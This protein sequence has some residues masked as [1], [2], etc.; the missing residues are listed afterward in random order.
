MP[1]VSVVIPAFN[2]DAFIGET[3][4]SVLAQTRRDLEIFVV[5]D[6]S[7]DTTREIVAAFGP[8][9]RLLQ[10][11]RGGPARARNAGARASAGTWLAFLD[12][13]DLWTPDKLER[14][15]DRAVETG[16]AMVVTD[17]INIG[18]RGSL[19]QRQSDIQPLADGDIFEALLAGNFITTSTVLLRRDA[20]EAAGGFGEDPVLPPAE[21][22]DFW[23]RVAHDHRVAACPEPLVYYRHHRAGISRNVQRMNASRVEVITR[24][25]GLPRGQALSAGRRRRIWAQTWSTN[26]WDAAR[27]GAHGAAIRAYGNAIRAW[28]SASGPYLDIMR[29][30]LGRF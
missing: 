21:D 25:L 19:P 14:Q 29:V 22:W 1:T 11:Q 24:A 2:A 7:S 5:D 13:D 9:V 27:S 16:A 8:P 12:A 28:P 26:G 30:L 15:V 17:R 4:R 6:G 23:L 18:D 10:Q 3:I 20:F